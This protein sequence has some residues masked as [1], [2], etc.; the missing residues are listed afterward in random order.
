MMNENE[1]GI[2]ELC[3]AVVALSPCAKN[4][5]IEEEDYD[6]ERMVSKKKFVN[7]KKTNTKI[8]KKTERIEDPVKVV[9]AAKNSRD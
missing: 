2:V 5:N 9:S 1:N 8:I 7:R 4:N 3:V 6:D